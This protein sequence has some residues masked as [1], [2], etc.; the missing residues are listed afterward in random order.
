MNSALYS[1]KLST[2]LSIP[3][4]KNMFVFIFKKDSKQI[5]NS[6]GKMQCLD[7]QFAFGS[8]K[9]ALTDDYQFLYMDSLNA[10]NH[11]AFDSDQIIETYFSGISTDLVPILLTQMEKAGKDAVQTARDRAMKLYIADKDAKIHTMTV[12][13]AT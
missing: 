5:K 8:R 7:R 4:F 11:K 1:V 10:K 12:F 2:Y 3:E 13:K 9:S 6:L